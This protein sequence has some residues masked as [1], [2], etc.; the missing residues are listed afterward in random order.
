MQK[1]YYSYIEGRR[2]RYV[3]RAKAPTAQRD[4]PEHIKK[5]CAVILVV[6]IEYGSDGGIASVVVARS[7]SKEPYSYSLRYYDLRNKNT[8][9]KEVAQKMLD[10]SPKPAVVYEFLRNNY[11]YIGGSEAKY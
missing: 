1:K 11:S 9:L 4:K 2:A 7:S 8:V 6:S 3:K 10:N 5:L